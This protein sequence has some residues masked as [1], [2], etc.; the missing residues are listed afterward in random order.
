MKTLLSGGVN[1]SPSSVSA[2]FE[3]LPTHTNRCCH[4]KNQCA[5][6]SSLKKNTL[7][8]IIFNRSVVHEGPICV[9]KCHNFSS[10]LTR[11]SQSTY[12]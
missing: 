12:K 3:E 9:A 2:H 8:V 10:S 6:M 11:I 7:S 5:M 4:G 1:L